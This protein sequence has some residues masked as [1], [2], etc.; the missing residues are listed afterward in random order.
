V[1]C[2]SY[3]W[4][5]KD[6]I[7]ESRERIKGRFVRIPF[8][9]DRGLFLGGGVLLSWFLFRTISGDGG[10]GLADRRSDLGDFFF[11]VLR[12]ASYPAREVFDGQAFAAF[13]LLGFSPRKPVSHHEKQGQEPKESF[14]HTLSIHGETIADEERS[15]ARCAG[16]SIRVGSRMIAQQDAE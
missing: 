12:G 1:A 8:G 10:D 7:Q 5:S 4:K 13:G 11:D 16:W 15:S 3:Q 9:R 2:A 14:R 6:N